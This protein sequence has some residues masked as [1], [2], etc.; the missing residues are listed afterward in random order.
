MKKLLLITVSL[1]I[2]CFVQSQT[3]IQKKASIKVIDE[4]VSKYNWDFTTIKKF[5]NNRNE[6]HFEINDWLYMISYEPIKGMVNRRNLNG[7]RKAYL[8]K[9]NI[10]NEKWELANSEPIFNHKK[11]KSGSIMYGKAENDLI[12]KVYTDNG[13]CI[14][15][16]ANIVN[17]SDEYY[18]YK[19]HTYTK[20]I[21]IYPQKKHSNGSITYEHVN[22]TFDFNLLKYEQR[23]GNVFKFNRYNT[24]NDDKYIGKVKIY[25]DYIE[26]DNKLISKISRKYYD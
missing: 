8:Y 17:V 11:T 5:A 1:F 4:R 10:N 15:I 19:T 22:M 14:A 7:M 6:L 13:I 18:G 26:K 21:Y 9:R 25:F 24:L 23:K 3:P 16:F 12:E 2:G 20:L